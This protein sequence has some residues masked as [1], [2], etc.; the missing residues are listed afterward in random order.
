LFFPFFFH[1]DLSL[2]KKN[3]Q[4][5]LDGTD[6]RRAETF[7]NHHKNKRK[8]W[9]Q[10]F[11]LEMFWL[12]WLNGAQLRLFFFRFFL[13]RTISMVYKLC[14]VGARLIFSAQS[15]VEESAQRRI[16]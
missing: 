7:S 15:L 11:V 12:L 16:D 8:F 10:R 14:C 1:P 2:N 13:F 5:C 4:V 6:K 9:A 3:K